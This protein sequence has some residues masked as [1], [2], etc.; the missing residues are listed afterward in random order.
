[1]KNENG[2]FYTDF[3]VWEA[4]L[5]LHHTSDPQATA[6]DTRKGLAAQSPWLQCVLYSS[7]AALM[8]YDERNFYIQVN[9]HN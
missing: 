2:H 4:Y 1:M 5:V 8:N 3:E 6:E 7:S 9:V